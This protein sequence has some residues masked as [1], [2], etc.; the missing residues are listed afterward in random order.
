MVVFWSNETIPIGVTSLLPIILLPSFD[1][2]TVN[3]VVP[4]FSKSI[5]SLFLGGFMI[6]IAVKKQ[7]CT[8]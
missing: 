7:D 3:Q 2:A 6:A 5:I 4:N 8:K 1:I